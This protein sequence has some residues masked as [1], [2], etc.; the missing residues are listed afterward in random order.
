[1]LNK[2]NLMRKQYQLNIDEINKLM[3]KINDGYCPLPEKFIT[4]GLFTCRA[5]SSKLFKNYIE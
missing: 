4:V 1:M 5:F 3:K 2:E